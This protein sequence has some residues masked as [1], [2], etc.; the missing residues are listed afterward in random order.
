MLYATY[1]GKL[2]AWFQ[3][4]C[5][6]PAATSEDLLQET[7]V[8]VVEKID[9]F[10]GGNFGAWVWKIAHNFMADEYRDTHK[11]AATE[12]SSNTDEGIARLE[13]LP[14]GGA[15]DPALRACVV[16]ALEEFAREERL[17]AD[18]LDRIA[19]DGWDAKAVAL[20]RG[21]NEGAAREYISQGRKRLCEYLAPCLELAASLTSHQTRGLP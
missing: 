18:I 21:G 6:L 2:K 13:A 16:R 17:Y 15:V 10:R 1:A 20:F 5:R 19:V 14:D 9:D 12:L 4:R 11:R 8:R 3:Y 7:L